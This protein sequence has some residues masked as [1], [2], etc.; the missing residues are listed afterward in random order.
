VAPAHFASFVEAAR[1]I[2]SEHKA[3]LLN[4]TVRDVEPDTDTFLRYADQRMLCLV[5]LFNQQKTPAAEQQ[6]E[7]LTQDLITAALSSNGR[8]YLT[9]RLHG[10]PSQIRQAY[11]RL[12]EFFALKRKYDPAEVFQ[13][14]F[15][16]KY[17]PG[18]SEATLA[19]TAKGLD[20]QN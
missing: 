10:T 9:Y 18:V 16:R 15:Y 6:M 5:M 19:L 12:D 2:I 11:P 1:T 8:Y 17:A 4:V 14:E 7:A 20:R 13:N 3:D